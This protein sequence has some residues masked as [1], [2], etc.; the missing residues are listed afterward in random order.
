M[1]TIREVI[2]LTGT[3]ESALRYYEERKLLEPSA[4]NPTGRK[5]WLYDD[6]AIWRL[7]LI[8]LFKR[9]GLSIE[10][11]E[12][13]MKSE[14]YMDENTLEKRRET[15]IEK[16]N[17]LDQQISATELLLLIEK[18]PNQNDNGEDQIRL[19]NKVVDAVNNKGEENDE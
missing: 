9:I 4:K 17:E 16:R 7:R 14:N 6:E 19:L 8:L 12:K 15:L 5:E 1:K 18:M 13:M 11:I 3:T 10:E 2:E